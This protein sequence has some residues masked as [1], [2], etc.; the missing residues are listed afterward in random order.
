MQ[1]EL[2]TCLEDQ[3]DMQ[4]EKLGPD[5]DARVLG[6]GTTEAKAW[7]DAARRLRSVK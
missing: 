4:F 5:L 3:Q 7:A 2:M 1:K 6:R